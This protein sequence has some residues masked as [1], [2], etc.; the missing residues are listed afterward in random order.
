MCKRLPPPTQ[1]AM[2][3]RLPP[4]TQEA[5]CK[6]LPPPTQE[7]MC[8]RLPHP[9]Q[10]AA[11]VP[12]RCR[13]RSCGRLSRGV[14]WWIGREGTPKGGWG[15]QLRLPATPVVMGGCGC[16]TLQRR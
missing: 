14:T 9:T 8:K 10:E 4:P 15:R 7:A 6:R 13:L 11:E 16:G 2:C 5:M 12:Q 3:K 1:D